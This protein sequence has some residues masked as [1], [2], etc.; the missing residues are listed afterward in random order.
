VGRQPPHSTARRTLEL[1]GRILKGIAD[2]RGCLGVG[3]SD[4]PRVDSAGFRRPCYVSHSVARRAWDSRGKSGRPAQ[5]V[6]PRIRVKLAV[7]SVKLP[8]IVWFTALRGPF[9]SSVS[10][11]ETRAIVESARFG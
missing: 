8:K 4:E 11:G 10:S 5:V 6:R 7:L 1:R 3:D 2:I 9:S